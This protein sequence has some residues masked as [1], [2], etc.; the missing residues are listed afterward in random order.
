M[1]VQG[2]EM[3]NNPTFP[4]H[5]RRYKSWLY[6]NPKGL[7]HALSG[8]A[9]PLLPTTSVLAMKLTPDPF[10]LSE[11]TSTKV[12]IIKKTKLLF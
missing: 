8:S 4:E 10:S 1:E 7:S 11:A 6:L 9:L 3:I 2:N 12:H 5:L